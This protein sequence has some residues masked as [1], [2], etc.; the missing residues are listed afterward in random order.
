M[1]NRAILGITV[2]KRNI[3]VPLLGIEPWPYR[4][5]QLSRY[6]LTSRRLCPTFIETVSGKFQLLKVVTY[7]IFM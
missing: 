2:A 7:S 5:L 6:M 4:H 1:S 3:P